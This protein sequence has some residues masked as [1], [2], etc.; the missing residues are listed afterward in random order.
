[1]VLLRHFLCNVRLQPYVWCINQRSI[2]TQSALLAGHSKWANIR[3]IKAQK[4]G[5]KAALFTRIAR[6]IRIA[7]QEGGGSSDPNVNSSLRSVID[8]GLRKNMPMASIQSTIKK[9]QQ[10]QSELKKYTLEMRY[11]QK[12][13]MIVTLFTDNFTLMKQDIATILRK[14][15]YIFGCLNV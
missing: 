11:K 2:K 9:C 1:M 13:F 12:V 14:N 3:H 10:S 6:Q 7:M 4:D 5:E 15:G 8:E